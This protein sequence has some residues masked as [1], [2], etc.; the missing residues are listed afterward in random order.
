M[1]YE[2][3]K[4]ELETIREGKKLLLNALKKADKKK[5]LIFYMEGELGSGKTH[6]IKG[7]GEGLGLNNVKS[8]TFV[9]MK[10]FIIVRS[11]PN[12]LK[13]NKKNFFHIDCY[14]IYDSDEAKQIFLDKVIQSPKVIVAIEWAE[15]IKDIIPRPY[16]EIKFEYAGKNERKIT[17]NKV[18]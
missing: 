8:P 14:R 2:I 13:K 9:L 7:I 18:E 4:N 11:V 17:I 12:S 1:A 5:P 16:F 15:R 10:K 6:F 3:T